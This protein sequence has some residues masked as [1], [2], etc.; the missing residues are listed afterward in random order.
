MAQDRIVVD[1]FDK[2][3]NKDNIYLDQIVFRTLPD[4]TVRLAFDPGNS[5]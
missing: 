4:P 2:Y 1:K 5:T 3:W